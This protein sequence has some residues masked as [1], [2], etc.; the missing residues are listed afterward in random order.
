MDIKT[1]YDL[2]IEENNDPFRDPPVLQ[3]YN[4]IMGRT[5]VPGFDGTGRIEDCP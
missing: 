4:G 2:L 1:H 5:G 3:K